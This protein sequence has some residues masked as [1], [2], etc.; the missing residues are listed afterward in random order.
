MNL[1]I[2]RKDVFSTGIYHRISYVQGKTSAINISFSTCVWHSTEHW[3]CF[4][5]DGVYVCILMV[6]QAS[7]NYELYITHIPTRAKWRIGPKYISRFRNDVP[8]TR[9]LCYFNNSH[10]LLKKGNV[11]SFSGVIHSS[12]TDLSRISPA[13]YVIAT[14]TRT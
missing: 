6:E 8:F 9:N 5:V 1:I 10:F 11:F 14:I 12:H 2:P 13:H 7:P 3:G 4:D